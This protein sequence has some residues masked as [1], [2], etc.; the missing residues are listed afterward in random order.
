MIVELK[1]GFRFEV[2]EVGEE[3]TYST[4]PLLKLNAEYANPNK[5]TVAEVHEHF[6][7][8]NL[9][10]IKIFKDQ[11]DNVPFLMY[12]EYIYLRYF[13]KNINPDTGHAHILIGVSSVKE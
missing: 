9:S 12:T 13:Q 11:T 6:T 5:I 10:S 7:T 8:A 4:L 3:L 2:D 1:D